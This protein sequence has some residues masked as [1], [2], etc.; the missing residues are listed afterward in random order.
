[1]QTSQA[2][3]CIVSDRLLPNLIPI[4]M[5]RPRRVFLITSADMV[6]KGLA[7]RLEQILG[8]LKFEVTT[9]KGLPSSGL[10]EISEYALEW[11][12]ATQEDFPD[13]QL[14]LNITG[15][16]KLMTIAFMQVM[17][18]EV[19][20]II[21]T[22]TQHDR[23]EQL[24]QGEKDAGKSQPLEPVLDL[25]L[26]L[27]AQ[28]MTL[29]SSLSDDTDWCRQADQRKALTKYLGKNAGGI[30]DLLGAVNG[31]CNQALDKGG[32]TLVEPIQKFNSRPGR[33]W[34]EAVNRI[35]EAGV[36]QWDE[37]RT[38]N[39]PST[40]AARYLGGGW[41][42]EFAWHQARDLNPDDIRLGAEG[43]WEGIRKGRNELDVVIVHNNRLLLIECK[44]L[45]IGRDSHS[46]D[47]MLYKLD[48]VGDDVKGLFGDVILLTARPPSEP[49]KDRAR[50]HGIQIVA[51][52]RFSRFQKELRV[53]MESGH[54]PA[55]G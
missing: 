54:F 17:S 11:L 2:H 30:G 37:E 49:V 25:P 19:S 34:R 8:N 28:G 16:N 15:G 35:V 23:L 31:L 3:I 50:H 45:R 55:S 12:L 24:S 29:R 42:E 43:T 39:F 14:V 41:L 51:A 22:D 9:S 13:L 1:M 47:E 18:G 36:V 48:S 27:A 33:R 32:K 21:Y 26:Y 44:T 40:D 4:L 20:R 38:L 6:K 10:K 46:D 53:W 7:R 5:H 52:E